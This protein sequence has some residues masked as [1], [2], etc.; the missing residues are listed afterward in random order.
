VA[1]VVR[2]GRSLVAI[3]HDGGVSWKS[4][5]FR[6]DDP[7]PPL[8]RVRFESQSVIWAVGGQSVFS[9]RDGGE[10]W[11][12]AHREPAATQFGAISIVRNSGIFVTGGW[13]LVLRSRNFGATWEKLK[14][15][16]GVE[17]RFLNSMDFA[18]A[19]H[20][21]VGGD[22]GTIIETKD[23]GETWEEEATGVDGFVRDIVVL[24]DRVY[25]AGD[26][27]FVLSRPIAARSGGSG[28]GKR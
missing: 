27:F 28:A 1:D 3:T 7:N 26:G 10:S 18:D 12:L 17:N 23:G 19:L 9:S 25:A 8:M 15:P 2:G 16:A 24:G 11:Q 14:V 21:W 20:G 6:T 13:G 5:T 22:R 4:H